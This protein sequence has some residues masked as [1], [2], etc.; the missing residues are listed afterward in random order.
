MLSTVYA[1][2]KRQT[3]PDVDIMRQV[4]EEPSTL[5]AY[6]DEEGTEGEGH[7]RREALREADCKDESNT[8]RI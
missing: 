6:L 3:A 7:A 5:V 4:E 1:L 2:C 8:C